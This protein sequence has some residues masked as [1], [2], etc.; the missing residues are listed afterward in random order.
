MS[1]GQYCVNRA[2]QSHSSDLA[3]LEGISA[4]GDYAYLQAAVLAPN[5]ELM[6]SRERDG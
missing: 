2:T 1:G 6:S 4:I 5:Q 3:P